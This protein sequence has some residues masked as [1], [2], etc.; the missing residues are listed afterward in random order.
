MES[1][2]ADHMLSSLNKA[3]KRRIRIRATL[4][5]VLSQAWS[6]GPVYSGADDVVWLNAEQQKSTTEAS[7][8]QAKQR[9][10][11]LL[12]YDQIGLSTTQMASMKADIFD[13]IRNYLVV[14]EQESSFEL[15]SENNNVMF[16][17]AVPI[18]RALRQ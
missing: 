3:R 4:K 12:V 14:D 9:L 11:V 8:D 10:Q 17:A 13:V 16:S 2:F 18:Q 7:K 1:K 6:R 15:S 5:R